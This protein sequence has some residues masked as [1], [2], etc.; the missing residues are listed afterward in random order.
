MKWA[1]A[2]AAAFLIAVAL[3]G[4]WLSSQRDNVLA[5]CRPTD[6]DSIHAQSIGRFR[7]ETDFTFFPPGYDCVYFDRHGHDLVHWRP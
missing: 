1:G 5:Q 3:W 7:I 2:A 4:A 6:R